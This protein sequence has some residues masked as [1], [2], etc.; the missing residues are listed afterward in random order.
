MVEVAGDAG[1]EDPAGEG[2]LTNRGIWI[3]ED[4]AGEACDQHTVC[5]KLPIGAR[6]A[7]V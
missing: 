6:F 5:R 7:H 1:A 3:A 2:G 4:V